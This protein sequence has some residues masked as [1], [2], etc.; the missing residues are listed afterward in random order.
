MKVK[1]V[2]ATLI[3]LYLQNGAWCANFEMTGGGQLHPEVGHNSGLIWATFFISFKN[4]S[5]I[6]GHRS[7]KS[8]KP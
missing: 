2:T 4:R 8:F 5:N 6:H 7:F 3:K 1:S